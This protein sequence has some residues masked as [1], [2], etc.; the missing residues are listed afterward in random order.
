MNPITFL[1][2]LAL[3]IIILLASA[4]AR[5]EQPPLTIEALK[6]AEYQSEWPAS[7]K[8]KLTDGTY[9]E[10]IVPG[11]ASKLIIKLSDHVAFG[12]LNGDGTDDS[13]VILVTSSGGSGT[14]FDLACVIN[15]NGTPK[16]VATEQLGD[17]VKLKSIAIK[18]GE[19]MVE[20]VTHGPKDPMC[21]P[22]LNATQTYKLQG[23]KLIRTN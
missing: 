6:N 16:H 17:R 15:D 4:C 2:L 21:C 3:S 18:S 7:K 1:K 19:I 12:D 8:A 20:M 14:F 23:D 10:E 9:Q 11:A 5:V 22:T 13:A